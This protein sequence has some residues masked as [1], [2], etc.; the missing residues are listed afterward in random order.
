MGVIQ[1]QGIKNSLVNYFATGI[2]FIAT[3][4]IYP[5]DLE[6]KGLIDFL[7]NLGVL[8]IP[9]AQFGLFAVYMKYFPCFKDRIGQFQRWIIKRLIT[10]LVLFVVIFYVFRNSLNQFLSWTE[11]D[12]TGNFETYSL[13]LPLVVFCI[14]VQA[15]LVTISISNQRIVVPDIIRNIIQKIYFPA[16]ILAK[17]YFELD[18]NTF[19]VLFFLYYCI[20][21]PLLLWYVTKN[22]FLKIRNLKP[23]EFTAEEKKEIK[24]YNN[25]SLLNDIS[26]QLSFKLDSIMVGS[27]ISLTQTGIYGIM[28]YMSNVLTTGSSSLLNITNPIVSEKM[29]KGD[30]NGVSGMYKKASITLL[31]FGIF[32][33]FIIWFLI[34]DI[35][36]LTKY[37][38]QLLIGKYVFLYLAIAKLFDMVTSINSYIL[39]Y[40]R[41]YKYNLVFVTILGISNVFLNLWLIPLYGI[42]GAALASLIA[43]VSF[44]LMK[45]TFIYLKLNI[46]PFSWDT[47][48]VL[49]IGA[50]SFLVLYFLPSGKFLANNYLNLGLKGIVIGGTVLLTFALPVYFLNISKE[51]NGLANKL[52]AKI[53]GRK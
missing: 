24:A 35:L 43:M 15:F 28:F 47:V 4:F 11:I 23:I 6:A 9:Y 5:F 36:G 21:I 45:L 18:T 34:H 22:G 27:L 16:I 14:L 33:F 39:V 42:E 12:K 7:I 31:I 30:I 20:T 41:Y 17:F 37:S 51:I 10:Q 38:Q 26:T 40:S 13:F 52:L 8:F 48:K 25:F 46:H 29:A 49:G 44:N 50:V 19:I 32:V 53:T 1:R 2:G 3:L